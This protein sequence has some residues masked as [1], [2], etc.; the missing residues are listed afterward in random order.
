[1]PVKD[2]LVASPQ[3]DCPAALWASALLSQ[4]LI[5]IKHDAR[6]IAH[7]NPKPFRAF[8]VICAAPGKP[9]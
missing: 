3:P 7:T 1:M 5:Q 8:C 6:A 2:E 4:V 9:S